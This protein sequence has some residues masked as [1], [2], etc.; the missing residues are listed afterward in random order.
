MVGM[1]HKTPSWLRQVRVFALNFLKHPKMLGSLI[2]SSSFLINRL[3]SQVDWRTA[4]VIV[5]YGPGVGTITAH[6]LRRMRPDSTL[7]VFETNDDFVH[8]MREQFRDPRLH[9]VHGSAADV[10]VELEHLGFDRADYVVS[11]IPFS[12]IPADVGASILAATRDILQ[13]SGAFLVYQFRSVVKP[14]LQRF[15][16]NVQGDWE[17]LNIPPVYIYRCTKSG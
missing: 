11:G 12:T 15:F 17:P 1:T 14:Y 3:L 5:E 4:Q 8:F 16:D 2:P 10:K 9:V 6:M 13:P 7:I